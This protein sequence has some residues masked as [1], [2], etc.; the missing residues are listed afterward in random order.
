MS[1]HEEDAVLSIAGAIRNYF[2]THPEAAD[3]ADG[4]QRWWLLPLLR[5]EP[6]RLVE[7]ALEQLVEEGVTQ[8]VVLEDG[9]VIYASSRRA[10]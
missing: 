5:E 3:S 2:A 8:R 10:S 1:A 6:L 4:I 9:R 7:Q